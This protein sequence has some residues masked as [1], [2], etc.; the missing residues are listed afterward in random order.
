MTFNPFDMEKPASVIDA[1]GLP[2]PRCVCG[3]NVFLALVS[4][5]DDDYDIAGWFT[6]GQCIECG[7]RV[8]LP[9]PLD[10]P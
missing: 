2:S 4:F 5:G 1:S 3:N 9:T 6:E 10:K 7:A 8:T